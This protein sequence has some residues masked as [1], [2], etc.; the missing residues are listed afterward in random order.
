MKRRLA[1]VTVL[2]VIAL[3]VPAVPVSAAAT[4]PCSF[5]VTMTD[6]TGTDVTVEAEPQRVVTL[7]PSAA[8][9]MWEI[10]AREKVVG[11]TK[12]ASYLEGADERTL[13]S[14]AEQIVVLERVVNLTPDLVLA[15]N[16]V[17]NETVAKLREA[18][19][20][21]YYFPRAGSVEGVYEKTRTIGRLTGEC[22]GAE[23][24]VGW[25]R[26]RLGVVREAVEGQAR[27]DVLYLFYG[28]TAGRGTF[29]DEII[30]TA[31]GNNL[32][33]DAGVES[34]RQL[35]AEV[36]VEQD[37]DWIVRNSDDPAIPS[38]DALNGT[39]AV[40]EGQIVVVQIEHLNQPA[41]RIVYAITRLAEHFHPEAYAAAN[42]T[43]TV[44]P[45]STRLAGPTASES[46]TLLRTTSPASPGQPGFGHL[47]AVA[48]VVGAVA[49]ARRLRSPDQGS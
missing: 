5:P 47:V 21:V 49:V 45:T 35:S 15:P 16:T 38:S 31:G 28:Y 17:P 9:T 4:Q 22:E 48:A 39:T 32:A 1:R 44:S 10:G 3:A 33:A 11:L 37:P 36:V 40:R 8:Q 46:P 29:I 13:V 6:A 30:E 27:P 2:V 7:N 26:D 19:L 25:M 23:A 18:G 14:G 41:P 20:T 43:P 24:T 34:Y 12:Y 42:A